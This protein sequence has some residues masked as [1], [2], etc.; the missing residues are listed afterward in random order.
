MSLFERFANGL[1]IPRARLGLSEDGKTPSAASSP[2]P[3]DR[4][5]ATPPDAAP[6]PAGEIEDRRLTIDIE[7]AEDGWVTMT[8][9]RE[10]FNGT[11]VPLTRMSHDLWFETTNGPLKIEALPS[12]DRNVLIQR[13][14]DTALNARFACQIF[15][16]IEPGES[17]EIG[18]RSTGGRFVYDHYWRQS[19]PRPTGLF[20]IRLR[21]HGITTLERCS[22]SEDRP[23]GSEISATESLSWN[24]DA[25]GVAIE[26]TRRNLRP[27]QAVTLRWDGAHVAS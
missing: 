18:Y 11:A 19:I 15:P 21:H 20:V 5:K 10:L 26:L 9:R 27:N 23:D 22:A 14:H 17:A 16:A 1:G 2:A 13:I 8:Y 7:V 3:T 25:D 6:P 4:A 24:Q 12:P